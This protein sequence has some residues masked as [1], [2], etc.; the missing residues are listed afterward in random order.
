MKRSRD[1]KN[2]KYPY[3]QLFYSSK[4]MASRR[5]SVCI[6]ETKSSPTGRKTLAAV[7]FMCLSSVL[8]LWGYFMFEV[9]R[10]NQT[11]HINL[12]GITFYKGGSY[13]EFV[14]NTILYLNFFSCCHVAMML[15]SKHS[16]F[17]RAL[18]GYNNIDPRQST[19]MTILSA[20]YFNTV[21]S[22]TCGLGDFF[23][24]S[25]I[26]MAVTTIQATAFYLLTAQFVYSLFFRHM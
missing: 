19:Q 21:L 6:E 22:S 8:S 25:S 13:D 4:A 18:C 12:F 26:S 7:E 14:F 10:P 20:I 23:P 1:I 15:A 17:A 16:N 2:K 11:D 24:V 3:M 9:L 5:M